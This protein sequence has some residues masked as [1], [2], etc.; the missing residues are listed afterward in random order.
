MR[1]PWEGSRYRL[2]LVEVLY[3]FY[4]F[5]SRFAGTVDSA[6]DRSLSFRIAQERSIVLSTVLFSFYFFFSELGHPSLVNAA[7]FTSAPSF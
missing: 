5:L 4:L 7:T 6:N 2:A 3:L 1:Y